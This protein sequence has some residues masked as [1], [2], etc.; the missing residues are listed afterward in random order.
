M[1]VQVYLGLGA[2]IEP[3]QC[4]RAGVAAVQQTFAQVHL[5]P[6]YQTQ[7]IGLDGP[8]FLNMVVALQTD[9]PLSALRDWIRLIEQQHGRQRSQPQPA[10]HRLDMDVLLYGER[11]SG[12]DHLPRADILQRAY[13]LKPLVDIA[14][15]LLYPGSQ[16]TMLELWQESSLGQTI[17]PFAMDFHDSQK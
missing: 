7:A 11:I 4:L 3:Q 15:Q 6:V 16:K 8:D 9:W 5:S 17:V 2:N 13:V 14:P 12:T 10:S 1:T